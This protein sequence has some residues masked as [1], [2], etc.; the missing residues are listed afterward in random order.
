M[1]PISELMSVNLIKVDLEPIDR[2]DAFHQIAKFLCDKDWIPP[3]AE[4]ELYDRLVKREA[5]CS[6]GLGHGV[7]MPHVYFEKLPKPMLLFARF[8]RT[9]DF[10]SQDGI[11]VDKFFLLMGP[12]RD[13]TEHLRIL[14]RLAR[15][16]KD[17]E[18]IAALK[19]AQSPEDILA[20]VKDVETRH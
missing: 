1:L 12:K 18:F 20:A 3:E 16:L 15:L 2:L 10:E 6:T 17:E 19:Q 8:Q 5:I 9:V 4:D 13:N 14:A 7:A 11:P